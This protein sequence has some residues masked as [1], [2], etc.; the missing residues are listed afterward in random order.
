MTQEEMRAQA[1]QNREKAQALLRLARDAEQNL[2]A[3]Q[4]KLGS[5]RGWGIA[6]MLGGGFIVNM[7]K[8]SKLDDAM[9]YIHRAKPQLQQLGKALE[10]VAL[11]FDLE[12]GV[13]G[14]AVFADFFLDGVFADVYMQSKIRDLQYQLEQAQRRLDEVILALH[15]LDAH[16]TERLRTLGT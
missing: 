14:F 7:I 3:A 8:H 5:A 11:D 4:D 1:Q 15:K 2:R 12:L 16:E 9:Q 10:Q 6:D 13:G